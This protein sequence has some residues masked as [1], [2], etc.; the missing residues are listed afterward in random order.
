MVDA[1]A[2]VRNGMCCN[3]ALGEPPQFIV[4]RRVIDV[5]S[6]RLLAFEN[7]WRRQGKCGSLA[8]MNLIANALARFALPR[9]FAVGLPS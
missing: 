6:F 4:L 8:A 9:A 3:A 5:R 1:S 7:S 2:G